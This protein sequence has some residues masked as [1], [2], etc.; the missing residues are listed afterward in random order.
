MT[1]DQVTFGAGANLGF[2]V[3]GRNQVDLRAEDGLHLA[4]SEQAHAK[5]QVRRADAAGWGPLAS[6]RWQPPSAPSATKP[7]HFIRL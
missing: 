6:H 7:D 4:R 2:E 3:A 1:E 5:R